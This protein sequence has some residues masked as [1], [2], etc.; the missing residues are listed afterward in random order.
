MAGIQF[1][2]E[3]QPFPEWLAAAQAGHRQMVTIFT[4]VIFDTSLV[5]ANT[6]F[7]DM[8]DWL[9][10][11]QPVMRTRADTLFVIRAHPDEDR[12]GKASRESV[13]E[14]FRSSGLAAQ[15]N[16]AFIGPTDY[17]SSYDL[18][19]RSKLVLVYNSSTGLEASILGVPVLCAGRARYSQIDPGL[20]PANRV[21]YLAQLN[22]LLEG[23]SLNASPALVR[24]ARKFLHHELFQVSLDFSAYLNPYPTIP[25]MVT[26]SEFEPASLQSDPIFSMLGRGSW[27]GQPSPPHLALK[28]RPGR[29]S[30]DAEGR[31]PSSWLSF[32]PPAVGTHY[33]L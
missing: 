9:R 3:M 17:I 27:K 12:P 20:L 28:R 33:P 1:W 8:F 21:E 26:F 13:A 22:G 29:R 14:W 10:A 6:L 25:G 16:V 24:R 31:A 15:T 30:Y 11:L 23:P 2:P 32:R 5:H 7:A 18:I 19:E 4:N